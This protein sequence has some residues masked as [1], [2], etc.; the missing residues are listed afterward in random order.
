[1][2][3]E[4][5]PGPGKRTSP[6]EKIINSIGMKLVLIPAGKFKMGSTEAERKEVL[7]L[8]A[9][10]PAQRFGVGLIGGGQVRVDPHL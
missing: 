2:R 6:K 5:K 3:A 7:R 10:D 8:L 1:M 4:A 9:K